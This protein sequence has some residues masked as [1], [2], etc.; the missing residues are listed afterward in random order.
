MKILNDLGSSNLKVLQDGCMNGNLINNISK[1][2]ANSIF[3]S[4]DIISC[5][6]MMQ[7]RKNVVAG[8]GGRLWV[9]GGGEGRRLV[10]VGG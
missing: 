2:N 10:G 1:I 3:K 9:V 4:T 6:K 7:S 5:S 8:C